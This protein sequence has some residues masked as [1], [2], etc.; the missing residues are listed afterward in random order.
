[1]LFSHFLGCQSLGEGGEG[2]LLGGGGGECGRNG[3]SV[4]EG[5]EGLCPVR[6]GGWR[7]AGRAPALMS[8][9]GL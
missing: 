9:A 3:G 2:G 4:Q 1:M 5:I 6:A 7:G 8:T